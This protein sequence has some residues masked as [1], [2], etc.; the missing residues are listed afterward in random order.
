MAMIE[1]NKH[2]SR[3]ELLWFGLLFLLF[4]GIIGGLIYWKFQAP[5]VAYRIWIGAAVVAGI[6]FIFPPVRR[7]LYL[8]WM[9]AAFP[10]GLVISSLVMVLIFY[11]VVTPIGLILRLMGRDSLCR[12]LDPGADTY[13]TE[14]DIDAPHGRYFRQF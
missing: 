4:F 12:A 7:P 14:R 9:Y 8:A 3:K 5:T 10:I 13:W 6:Y 2:P 1:I 11:A